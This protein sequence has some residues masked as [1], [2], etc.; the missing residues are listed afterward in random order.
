METLTREAHAGHGDAPLTLRYT[1]RAM[2]GRGSFGCVYEVE[3]EG[4]C[5]DTGAGAVR[6]ADTG[7]HAEESC[8]KPSEAGGRP[9]GSATGSPLRRGRRAAIKRVLQDRRFK[10]RELEIMKVIH[11][12]NVVDLLAY[13]LEETPTHEVYLHLVLEFVPETL[14]TATQWFHSRQRQMPALPLRLYA[15]QLFRALNYIH[16]YG[17]CHRDIKPQNVLLDPMRGV[18]K[19]CDFGSAKILSP[20]EPNVSYICSRYYRAPELIFGARNYTTKIDVWS[21]GCVVAEMCLGQPLFPGQ[22]GI[23]QLVEIIKLLGTPCKYQIRGMN[24]NYMEHKFPSIRPIPLTRVFPNVEGDVV[25]LFEALFAYAP[26]DRPSAA[27]VLSHSCFDVLR[28]RDFAQ[29][30]FPN[31]RGYSNPA[32]IRMPQVLDFSQRELSMEPQLYET[33][34][35]QWYRTE[36]ALPPLTAYSREQLA[37]LTLS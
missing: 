32:E 8:S 11:H 26:C 4:D 22:S 34:V 5:A 6:D 16:S 19:L 31:Y 24:P 17:V 29:S 3:L 20:D 28:T 1:Q 25:A 12:R 23:D 9:I 30:I 10:N 18:L 21:A 2:V 37:D 33:L 14:Y 27:K 13:F 36:H 35:P 7:T 15:Y